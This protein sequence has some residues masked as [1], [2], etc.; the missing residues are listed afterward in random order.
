MPKA[1][2]F[3]CDANYAPF[4]VALASQI[5]GLHSDRDFDVCI[6][7]SNKITIPPALEGLGIKLRNL[8]INRA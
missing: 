2:A 4:S 6:F 1:I 8:W 7:S 5:A 3:A